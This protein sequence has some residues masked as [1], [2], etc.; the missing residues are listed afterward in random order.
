M[1]KEKRIAYANKEFYRIKDLNTGLY[2]L[3]RIGSYSE[4]E[5]NILKQKYK[6]SYKP[7]Q[8]VQYGYSYAHNQVYF[9]HFDEVGHFYPTYKGAERMLS[10]FVGCSIHDR[11]TPAG[12]IF[13]SKFNFIVVKS[14]M[15]IKDIKE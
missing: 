9:L 5:Q 12:R 7:K 3:G 1:G 13:N 14:Q 15:K 2:Y 6:Y 8:M 10:E 11:K 4:D